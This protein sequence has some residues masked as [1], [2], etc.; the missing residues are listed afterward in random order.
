[1]LN[2]TKKLEVISDPDMYLFFEKGMAGRVSY[3]SNR[4]SKA[5]NK[6]L[7]TYDPNQESKHIIY[8]DANSLYGYAMSKFLPTIGFE[9]S[10]PKEFD[11]NKYTRNNSKECVLKVDLEYPKELQESRN[12]YKL[13]P[14]KIE[15]KKEVLYE[16][17]LKIII[18]FLLVMLKN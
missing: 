3:V 18:T 12:N 15:I 17:Q 1:M 14:D 6:Y 16:Y 2:M 5:N 7:K 10:Y 9:W 4:Y 13:A 8:L 11:L